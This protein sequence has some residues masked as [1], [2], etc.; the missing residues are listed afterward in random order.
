MNVGRLFIMIGVKRRR[1]FE[2]IPFHF[3]FFFFF[4]IHL[5]ISPHNLGGGKQQK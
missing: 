3:F 1:R 4:L 2:I 5:F